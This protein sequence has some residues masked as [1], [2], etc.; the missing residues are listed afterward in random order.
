MSSRRSSPTSPH[1]ETT[2]EYI[3]RR[4]GLLPSQY[5]TSRELKEWVRKNKDSKYVPPQLLEAWGFNVN[6]EVFGETASAF[7]RTA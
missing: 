1:G 2:F 6:D 3:V 7:K 4:L 5:T